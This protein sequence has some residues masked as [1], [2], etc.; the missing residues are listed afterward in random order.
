MTMT[1]TVG[2]KVHQSLRLSPV[3]EDGVTRHDEEFV[4]NGANHSEQKDGYGVTRGVLASAF[5]SWWE[6]AKQVSPTL[7]A[8]VKIIDDDI[9]H[10]D[11][12]P[13]FKAE[14]ERS[15]EEKAAISKASEDKAT[16][17]DDAPDPDD[18]AGPGDSEDPTPDSEDDTPSE[19]DP[20]TAPADAGVLPQNPALPAEPVEAVNQ[21]P[22][23]EPGTATTEHATGVAV[24]HVEQ[25]PE[26][27]HKSEE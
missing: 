5:H 3:D 10:K 15:D 17:D 13:D 19:T 6:H 1:V 26:P 25:Q 8:A 14:A 18:S 22:E 21:H 12:M 7:A 23:P 24:G 20:G 4:L 27:E 16:E 9:L 2:S 11:S